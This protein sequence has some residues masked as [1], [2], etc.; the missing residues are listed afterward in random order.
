MF[1]SVALEKLRVG[2]VPAYKAVVN[3][4]GPKRLMLIFIGMKVGFPI[5]I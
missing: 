1:M 4:F 3:S 5:T 2:Y